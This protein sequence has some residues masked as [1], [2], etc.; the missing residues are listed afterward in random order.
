MRNSA[1][2]SRRPEWPSPPRSSTPDSVTTAP[3]STCTHTDRI[4]AADRHQC[5]A[6]PSITIGPDGSA[7]SSVL[8]NVIVCGVREDC[9]VK[10]DHAAGQV[11]VGV[12]LLDHVDQ[13]ARVARPAPLALV[14]ST[15]YTVGEPIVAGRSNAP[16]STDVPATRG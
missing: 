9:R 14:R 6:G 11:S 15:V 7:S 4:V 3:L 13:V 12:G 10:L 2:G 16:M 8:D 5:R 1:P